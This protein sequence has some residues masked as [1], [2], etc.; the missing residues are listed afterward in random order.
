L[1]ITNFTDNQ[2]LDIINCPNLK[3]LDCS[4]NQL[5][6]LDVNECQNLRFLDCHCNK[7]TS[8][9]FANLEQLDCSSN[10][11]VSLSLCPKLTFLKISDNN[12]SEQDLSV[13]SK[14]QLIDLET[15]YIGNSYYRKIKSGNYNTF[16]GSLESL[17]D[18]TKLKS[19]DI[20]NTDVEGDL[21]YL[22]EETYCSSEARPESK[23]KTIEEALKNSE[24]FTFN[25]GKYTR[26]KE[27]YIFEEHNF[28]DYLR[29]NATRV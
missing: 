10:L 12:I 1:D 16:T 25:E 23:V 8:L 2:K 28:K 7:L 18:L 5:S 17:K 3:G 29:R 9:K 11:L 22:P 14:L 21:R 24:S 15:L 27:V 19:L 4:N 20:S 13:F 26:K 6:S